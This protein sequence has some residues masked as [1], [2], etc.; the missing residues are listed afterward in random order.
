MEPTIASI[1]K[2]GA[3]WVAIHPYAG[4]RG[5]GEVRSRGLDPDRPPAWLTH[6]IEEAHRQG[7]KIL[8]KPH[9]A[10]WGSPFSWRGEISF[11]TEAQWDR[12]WEGYR[13]W[14]LTLAEICKDA[15]G[16]VV[17]TE[18]DRTLGREQQWRQLIGEVRERCTAPLTY[19]ANWDHYRQVK[20]W[21]SLDVIGI[22]AYF[23]VAQQRGAGEEEIR[24]GW[25][26]RME[27]LREYAGRQGR[28]IVF[29]ELGYNRSFMAPVRP[30]E[31][32]VDGPE[33]EVL[34][35]LC[36]RI[37]LEAIEKEPRVLGAFLWKWFPHPYPVGRNFQIASP[38]LQEIITGVWQ[39]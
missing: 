25:R 33:A 28:N 16:F 35:A 8:I 26:Q 18:L 21:D 20:F 11:A 10:Y 9:L 27:E 31:S 19:A 39:G 2:V 30:W 24:R 36:L 4:I 6:P 34:Q 14:I 23:P 5:T 29:T 13:A 37:A 22:Q 38:A 12:F 17:G 3:E 32:D 7:L 1:A 15:D